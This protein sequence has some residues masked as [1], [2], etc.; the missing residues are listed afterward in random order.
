MKYKSLVLLLIA[1]LMLGCL[2][3]CA[4]TG[5]QD[6][7]DEATPTVEPVESTD[8]ATTAVRDYD[9]ARAKYPLDTIVMTVNGSDVSWGEYFYWLYYSI[10][11][12]EQYLGTIPDLSET[13]AFDDTMTY[14]QY[15]ASSAKDMV[16]QYHALEMNA[17]AAGAELTAEDEESLRELLASDIV[18]C[19]GED[20]TE[21]DFYDYLE[22]M[23][24][25]QDLYNYIN[26][27]SCLYTNCF[28]AL[29]DADGETLSDADVQAFIDANGYMTAKHILLKTV[30]S[31]GTAISDEEIAA[32]LATAEDIVAQLGAA[33]DQDAR[34]ALFEELMAEYNE[35]TS[36]DY[37]PGGYCFAS[38]EMV[39]EFESATAA[40][41]EYETSGVVESDY[42]Y[43]IILRMPTTPDDVV[44]YYSEDEQYDLR[45]LAAVDAYDVVIGNWIADA[46]VVWASDFE[47][48]DLG[49]LFA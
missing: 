27:V 23:Y 18:S 31:E 44:E 24:V 30:D 28:D 35:D 20:G 36:E 33:S 10:S 17:K 25:S 4:G 6:Y 38:G 26:S 21:T 45:Y 15:F 40:L 8:A 34:I 37:Y 48:M 29:Y 46:E 13:C 16:V 3:G 12:V 9:A 47:N 19:C 22:S 2:T 7:N 1:V 5:V 11:Y 41:S 39:E 32:K 14:S 42:G 43:H 49:T